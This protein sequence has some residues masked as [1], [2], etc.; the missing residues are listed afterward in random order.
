[1]L[2]KYVGAMAIISSSG[3]GFDHTKPDK[4]IFLNAVVELLEAFSYGATSITKHLHRLHETQYKGDELLEILKKYC[5]HLEE[6]F[7]LKKEKTDTL[8]KDLIQRIH[9]NNNLNEE[10]E[11]TWLNNIELMKDYS[12]QYISNETAYIS[13]LEVIGQEIHDARIQEMTFPMFRNYDL[14]L[15]DL[16]HVL[17]NKKPPI[18]GVLDITMTKD[19][20]VGILTIRHR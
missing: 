7:K 16:I 1:M 18:D 17:E 2:L 8:E 15:Q 6:D 4:Y 10:E 11:R 20:L 19:G 12:Y 13:G 9:D 5:P 14:V 3:I